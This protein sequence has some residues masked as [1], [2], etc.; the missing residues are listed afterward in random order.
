[1]SIAVINNANIEWACGYG[2]LEMNGNKQV[3]PDTLFQAASIIQV[4][5]NCLTER[6]AA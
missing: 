6:P 1:V 5:L 3:S 4:N 2:V